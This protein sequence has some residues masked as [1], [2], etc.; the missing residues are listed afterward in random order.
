MEELPIIQKTYDLI[1]WYV[2]ILNRLPKAHKFTLADRMINRLYDISE[3]LIVARYA[4]EKLERLQSVNV[5]LDILRS[6]TRLLLDFRLIA[7]RRYE[8]AIKSINDIGVELGG[9]MKQQS[10]RKQF[11]YSY[12][13]IS[14]V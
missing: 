10:K 14:N 9:W 3:G 5:Q 8:Y 12:S 6:Q 1:K 4:K 2:P 11:Q 13:S 7:V